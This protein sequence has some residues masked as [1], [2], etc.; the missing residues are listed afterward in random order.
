MSISFSLLKNQE[1][2]EEVLSTFSLIPLILPPPLPSDSYHHCLQLVISW[3]ATKLLKIR[4]YTQN[5]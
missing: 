5:D 4:N 3:A 1:D 2:G